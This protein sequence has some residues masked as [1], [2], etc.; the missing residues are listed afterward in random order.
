MVYDEIAFYWIIKN[1]WL[2]LKDHFQNQSCK[3]E[4]TNLLILVTQM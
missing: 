1:I 4:M 2:T 3:S